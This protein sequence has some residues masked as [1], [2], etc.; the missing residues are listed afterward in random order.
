MTKAILLNAASLAAHAAAVPAGVRGA[1]RMDA[2]GNV[3]KLLGQVRQELER[4]SSDVRKVAEDALSQS[5]R[6]GDLTAETK[7]T[8][9]K[10][11]AE[12]HG[13]SNAMS[14]LEGQLEGLET[15]NKDLEQ[16]VAAGLGGRGSAPQ[17]VGQEIAA[18]DDLKAWVGRGVQGSIV[19]APQN[20]ITSASGSGGGLIWP[21]E[22]RTP[23]NLPRQRLPIRAL[24]TLAT[25]ESD[26]V[27]YARQVLRDDNAGMTAEG[28]ASPESS[29]GWEQ[30]E[31]NVRKIAHHTNI[32][33]EALSDSGQ[34]Q[35]EIDGEMR[36]GLD[37]KEEQQILSGDGTGQNL[38]GLLTSAEA[39]AASAGLPNATRIDRLRLG[40]LQ[41]ALGNYAANGIT[42]HPID[43]AGIELLKDTQGRYIFGNPNTQSTPVLWGLDVVPT[44]SHSA[45]EW[46]TGNF[47]M[48]A[49]LYDR[50]Q[51]EI[52]ISTEHGTNF[53]EGLVTMQG[54]KRLAMAT[55][56]S[57]ALVT[58]DFTFA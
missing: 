35:G 29:Y 25:T 53:V 40:L 11:L 20:A 8:A 26:V 2:G 24:L 28:A 56:R 34:L 45:G 6:N 18:S 27:K 38:L 23:A 10:A 5:K 36:Y 42:L 13:L 19:L 1:P 46:M 4:V 9:D 30:A 41:V 43:W 22:D 17:T 58:G 52:L 47:A 31:A 55:K 16:H 48:A 39:F 12:F 21:T 33:K 14:K 49:T 57:T 15:R 50:Q 51:S 37:L 32:S 3:E 54:S 44:L 7:T